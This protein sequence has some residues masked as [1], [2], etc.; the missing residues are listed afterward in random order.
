MAGQGDS[1]DAERQICCS[2]TA[3]LLRLVRAQ[4]GDA[5]VRQVI[6]AAGSERDASFLEN[7]ENW[8]SL[9]EA[10]ALLSAA[11]EITG[12]PE[13]AR[14][15]GA[16]AVRQHSGS[17]VATLLRS[18]GSP[19]A[20]L[21]SIAVTA[22]KFGTVTRLEAIESEPGRA[23]VRA[24]SRDG[25][26]RH[27]LHCM[28]TSGLLSTPTE[29]FGLPQ[30]GVEESECQARGGRQCLYTV[31]WDKDL[32]AAAA[33]PQ[34]RITALEA[35]LAAMSE[36]LDSAYAT[37]SDLVS[38]DELATVLARI[39]DRA[40]NAV[41]APGYILA[42]RPRPG[43][44]L[45]VY[46]HGVDSAEAVE[47]AAVVVGDGRAPVASTLVAEVAS[48]RRS[49]GRLIARYPPGLQFFPEEQRSLS[50]YAKH[51]AAV[52]DMAVA[53]DEAAH[54]HD[55]VSAL[56]ALSHALARAGTS[57][58]VAERLTEAVPEVVDSD[59][60]G[61]WIWDD[62]ARC[63]RVA[64]TSGN[65]DRV[66]ARLVRMTIGAGDTPH[67]ARM[68]QE[69]EPLFF[70]RDTDDPFMRELID[71]LGVAA[72]VV[73]PI[74]ARDEFLGILTASVVDR[75]ERLRSAPELLERLTGVAALAA[76]ALQNGRLV[77][78]LAYEASHDGLTGVLNR[79]GFGQRIERVIRGAASRVGLLFIDL[80]GFK[81]VND[82]HGHDAGDELLR[83]A[84]QRLNQVVR[85]VDAVG[86]LGGDE[87]AIILADVNA[88]RDVAAAAGRVRAAFEQPFTLAGEQVTVTASV[89]E[90]TWPD[91]GRTV[92]AV[93]RQ[94][95]AAMYHH[96]ALARSQG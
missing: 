49:Y 52:L 91:A 34:Q 48:S 11:T 66:R 50:L 46:S 4:A 96:K 86:R 95:D 35:Q 3:V 53:L 5:A 14:Q 69:P 61:V 22:T 29:L 40:A 55:H 25:F 92:D 42:V 39:V 59:R 28:W 77:D 20:V 87:F 43:A 44:E 57:Y 8:I 79:A 26:P 38:P 81:Q 58:E 84:A 9:A 90:A 17:P 18:L 85:D 73:V 41:R 23:V 33:D 71:Q 27:P 63:L 16:Q 76:P 70:T 12:D 67:L 45:Q 13:F 1:A 21:N 80:D 88:E 64:A 10:M 60:M 19:E 31:S 94:A 7:L 56:L 51:A 62:T 83:Q 82:L 37:A 15:V 75:P 54:R 68:L 6:E 74:V 65:P 78:E 89:G 93:I 32:A 47:I 36:R 2:M 72:L 30:A 24:V